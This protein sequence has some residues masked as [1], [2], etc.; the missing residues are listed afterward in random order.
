MI[1]ARLA[2]ALC[3][4][5]PAAAQDYVS[6]PEGPLPDED[7][8][9]LVACS[10]PPGGACKDP[11]VR[12]PAAVAANLTVGVVA[13][14]PDFPTSR[15]AL[16]RDAL[17][18]AID[19]INAADVGLVLRRPPD[20]T[21]PDI[22]V[23]LVALTEN[24]RLDGSIDPELEGVEIGAGYVHVWWNSRAEITRAIILFA[25]DI[26]REDIP[27]IVLEELVQAMGLLTDIDNRWYTTR[28]I[29]AENGN[30]LTRL[31][32]Q[33]IMALRRHYAE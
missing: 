9:R 10:A 4:A 20:G 24:A 31:Q 17:S 33:D 22:A 23:H 16:I 28:S 32:P 15:Q 27:S 1:R 5:L 13:V 29:F 3:I 21:R 19:E 2:A 18:N 11:I 25:R 6:V 12:W 7:F 26:R 14:D 30:T 8:Y